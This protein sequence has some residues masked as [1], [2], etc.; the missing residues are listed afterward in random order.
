MA[1]SLEDRFYEKLM[2]IPE[3]GCL[4]YLGYADKFGYG[5]ISVT[6]STNERTHRVA[7]MLKHGKIPEGMCVLHKCDVPSCCNVEHLFLGTRTDNAID[8]A[9]KG[10]ALK[11][12]KI[13]DVKKIKQ[14]TESQIDICNFFGI[15]QSM[16]SMIKNGKEG[17][18]V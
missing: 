18:F 1:K 12:L 13:D 11:K 2:P 7:W 15:S 9:K 17:R 4:I 6:S 16:V 10:R 3:S 5:K 14:S 8:K